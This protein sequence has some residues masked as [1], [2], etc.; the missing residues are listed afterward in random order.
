M[1]PEFSVSPNL[2]EQVA[3]SHQRQFKRPAQ[4]RLLQMQKESIIPDL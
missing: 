3:F 2:K 4:M 1:T